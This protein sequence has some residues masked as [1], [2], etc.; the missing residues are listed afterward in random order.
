MNKLLK[1]LLLSSILLMILILS[2]TPHC[3]IKYKMK[4]LRYSVKDMEAEVLEVVRL[5]EPIY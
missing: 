4:A 1:Y 5:V 3:K 2:H